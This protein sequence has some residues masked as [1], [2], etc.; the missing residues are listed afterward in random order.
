VGDGDQ[1][2]YVGAGWMPKVTRKMTVVN[3]AE[4]GVSVVAELTVAS[5]RGL[6]V[7]WSQL[8]ARERQESSGQS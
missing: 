5:V 8:A 7:E 2:A 6:D 4:S 3:G 1:W